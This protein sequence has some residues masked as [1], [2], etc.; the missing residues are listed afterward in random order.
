MSEKKEKTTVL[1]SGGFDPVH[2]GHLRMFKEAK[3][4]GDELIVLINNDYWLVEKRKKQEGIP[5]KNFM[6]QEDRKEIIESF[7]FVDKVVIT[8]HQEG[9]KDLSICE[10]LKKIK[11]DV[12]AN[13]GDRASDNI[14]EYELCKE[15]GIKMVFGV[16]GGKERNSSKILKSWLNNG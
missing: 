15:L 4:L 5:S 6:K 16:G 13:G 14:P 3:K 11:P 8:N 1:V 9:T 12:Y 7:E 10:D 2:V